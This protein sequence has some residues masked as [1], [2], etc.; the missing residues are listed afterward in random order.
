MFHRF[1]WKIKIENSLRAI[2]EMEPHVLEKSDV[3]DN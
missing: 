1:A 3:T 2:K